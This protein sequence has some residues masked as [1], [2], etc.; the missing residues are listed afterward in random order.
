MKGYDLPEQLGFDGATQEERVYKNAIERTR[1]AY[2]SA[3]GKPLHVAFSGGKDS[4]A[5]WGIVC[6]AAALDGVPIEQYAVRHY[7]VTGIDPPELVYHM[8][9]HCPDLVW[10]MYNTSFWRLIVKNGP[11]TRLKRWCCKELKELGGRG[12]MCLTGVRWAESLKRQGRAAFE[13]ITRKK[14]DKILL[15]DNDDAR[16]YFEHCIPKEKRICNPIVDWT[17]DNVWRYIH[18]RQLPY[19]K[20]YDEGFRRLGCIGCPLAGAIREAEFKR[21]PKFK[22]LY[23]RAFDKMLERLIE[24]GIPNTPGWES[25][26]DVFDWW[27]G[28]GNLDK[29]LPGQ[30]EWEDYDE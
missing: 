15:N 23:I 3:G 19:C 29:P 22:Q 10:D 21:W 30:I 14:A 18:E 12:S 24:K 6:E 1:L 7:N 25:G 16:R 2:A 4:T 26:R 17:E 8:R 11:P 28:D 27:M 13:N 9:E 20:L 5:M